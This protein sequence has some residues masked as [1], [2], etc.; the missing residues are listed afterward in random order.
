[1]RRWSCLFFPLSLNFIFDLFFP[2]YFFF[3]VP[4][5]SQR[6]EFLFGRILSIRVM[7]YGGPSMRNGPANGRSRIARL[8]RVRGMEA[9]LPWATFVDVNKVLG[10]APARHYLPAHHHPSIYACCPSLPAVG[11]RCR[12]LTRAPESLPPTTCVYIAP[13]Q[14]HLPSRRL[15]RR[16]F[17]KNRH[18]IR[19]FRRLR[20]IWLCSPS[21]CACPRAFWWRWC[22]IYSPISPRFPWAVSLGSLKNFT[23]F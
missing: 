13:M 18:S 21:L 5:L 17:L 9:A 4:L 6:G 12:R 16:H 3:F 8:G 23:Y 10:G 20:R 11:P 19:I 15:S 7:R 14:L 2:V 22:W 1:M